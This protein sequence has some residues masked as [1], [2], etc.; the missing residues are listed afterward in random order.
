MLGHELGLFNLEANLSPHRLGGNC[1]RLMEE[2]L[3]E[4][5][6]RARE[7]AKRFDTDIALVGILPTLTKSNLGL[8]SMVPTPR[9][10]ALNDAICQM[11]GKDFEFT[12]NGIDQLSMQHDNVMLEA[13]N[14][15]FQ[16]HFQVGPDE[17]AKLYNLAQAITAPVL[18]AAVNSPV[19]LG[20]RLFEFF[21][22]PVPLARL[23]ESVAH[24]HTGFQ[25]IHDFV[26][27]FLTENFKT[28]HVFSFGIGYRSCSLHPAAGSYSDPVRWPWRQCA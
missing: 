6:I 28:G 15:S 10:H 8:D 17:F 5:Y 25:N 3:Q 1:L 7:A 24:Q 13:C 12:I 18:A 26:A 2:E 22:F 9:Y 4:I 16:V 20:K 23:V 21:G 11:R 27:F 19:L 14:T